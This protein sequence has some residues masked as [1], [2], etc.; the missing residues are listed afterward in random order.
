VSHFRQR[1][2]ATHPEESELL[3]AAAGALRS[4]LRRIALD[5]VFPGRR[6]REPRDPDRLISEEAAGIVT[7]GGTLTRR[8]AAYEEP[9][10]GETGRWRH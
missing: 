4:P 7:A 5:V 6:E 9:I 1:A 2:T 10:Q 8:E 3:L